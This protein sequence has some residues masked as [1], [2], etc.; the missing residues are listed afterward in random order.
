MS[1]KL[2][3][4]FRIGCIGLILLLWGAVAH[5]Q[6]P[7]VQVK[8]AFDSTHILTGD[9]LRLHLSAEGE[10]THTLSF[11]PS[12][13]WRLFNCEVLKSGTPESRQQHGKTVLTQEFV[14]T[15]FDTGRAVIAPIV[16][17]LDDTLPAALT[18]T[19]YFYVD[20]LPG[21]VDTTQ[22]FRDIKMPLGGI[23]KSPQEKSKAWVWILVV[24]G[25]AVLVTLLVLFFKRWLPKLREK[26]RAKL[27]EQRRMSSGAVALS[28]IKELRAKELC[29]K[30]M[31]KE[32]YSEL[33]EILRT[34]LDDQWDVN[35]MEMVT[36]EIMQAMAQLD[37]TEQQRLEIQEFLRLS[38]LVK[39][40][41]RQPEQAENARHLDHVTDFVRTT[42]QQEQARRAQQK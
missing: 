18:D 24:V 1:Q 37:V 10:G 41:R 21:G 11:Q 2:F 28:H 35:A 17:M 9:H 39:Y 38:D 19:L 3:I 36:D 25:L 34:Y 6:T 12:D 14:V 8:A 26:H 40:A 16:L 20:T 32:H 22:A 42:D 4:P 5:A 27:R 7:S 33:S 31:P 29:E 23:E 30:G 13:T 15:A